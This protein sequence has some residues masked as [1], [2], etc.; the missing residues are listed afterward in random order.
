VNNKKKTATQD[1]YQFYLKKKKKEKMQGVGEGK[2]N[3]KKCSFL[4]F[5]IIG[6]T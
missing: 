1:S 4:H 5:W 2:G 3:L 6:C